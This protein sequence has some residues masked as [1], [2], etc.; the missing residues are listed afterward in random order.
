MYVGFICDDNQK[1]LNLREVK[2]NKDVYDHALKAYRGKSVI[3]PLM[4]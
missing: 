1:R 4:Q 2:K 3:A